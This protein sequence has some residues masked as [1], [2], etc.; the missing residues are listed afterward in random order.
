MAQSVEHVTLNL[1]SSSL[2][3]EVE[4]TRKKKSLTSTVD[5]PTKM[6]N[7]INDCSKYRVLTVVSGHNASKLFLIT[8]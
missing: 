6:K 3:L 8:S 2:I 1:M 7:S 4:I 5:T